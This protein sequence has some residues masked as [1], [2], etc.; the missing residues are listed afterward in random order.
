MAEQNSAKQPTPEKNEPL[1]PAFSQQKRSR[2][3]TFDLHPDIPMS[4]RHTFDLAFHEVPEAG[5]KER[6]RRNM[7]AIRVLKECE[8][9]NRLQHPKNRRY[10]HSMSVGA[11]F[12]KHL[13]KTIPRGRTSLSSFT[14]PFLPMSMKA[15]GQVRLPLSTPRPLSFPRSTRQWNRWDLRRAISWSL[16]AVSATLSVCC[17]VQCRTAKFTAWRSTKSRQVSHSS[18]IRKPR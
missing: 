16:P 9:D 4:E 15:Q 11:V 1:T 14:L 3:Q 18:F 2:I 6:F 12:Q 10:Y 8:F 7:E 13:M 17:P 5:K